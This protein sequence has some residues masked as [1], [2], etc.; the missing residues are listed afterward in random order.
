ML[1]TRP[2]KP[3]AEKPF[4]EAAV[5]TALCCL[6]PRRA[7]GMSRSPPMRKRVQLSCMG[8]K[9][10]ATVLSA[11]S[12]ELKNTVARKMKIYPRF[13]AYSRKK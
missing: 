4:H 5:S 10:C 8:L 9:S 1:T 6:S 2:R 13:M 3:R 12:M 11:T 7:K